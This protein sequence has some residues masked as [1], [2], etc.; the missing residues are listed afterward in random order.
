MKK[1]LYFLSLFLSI[2]IFFLSFYAIMSFEKFNID[3]DVNIIRFLSSDNM[4]GRLPG[5]YGNNL[6]AD[7][8]KN[9]FKAH[10]LKPYNNDY[11]ESFTIKTPVLNG[12]S[13]YLNI[14]DKNNLIIKSYKYG[15]DFKE[16]FLSLN[17]CWFSFSADDKISIKNNSLYILHNNLKY[18]LI[19]ADSLEMR[20][21]YIYDKSAPLSILITQD[22]YKDIIKS[23]SKNYIVE[24][25]IP[26]S[27]KDSSVCNVAGIIHG[28]NSSLPPLIITAHYDHVGYDYNG[29]I[30]HGALDN[31][32]GTAFMLSLCN[33]L[34]SMLPPERDIIFVAFNCEEY[35]FLGSKNFIDKNYSKIKDAKVLNFD[36]IG[37]SASSPLTIMTGSNND[38]PLYLSLKNTASRKNI[39]FSVVSEDMSDHYSFTNRNID[40]VT[41][42]D[43][44]SL[45]IH[46]ANDTYDKINKANIKRA[47]SLVYP[48][49]IKYAYGNHYPFFLYNKCTLFISLLLII[50]LFL[51]GTIEK[52][53]DNEI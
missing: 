23:L 43:F 24:G 8:I 38:S 41:I 2:F 40:A 31:A 49:I 32:S 30:Y 34:S 21:S 25:N 1:K 16:S 42:C 51:I 33:T 35:G 28:I 20:Y 36:M 50:F 37:G 15:T 45:R 19:C 12:S 47:Y 5:T 13:P 3:N 48:D 22:V 18:S 9:S 17:N 46:T 7:Y 39:N 11:Y 27:V 53:T 14:K 52:K 6:A 26:Y 29:K 4:Q 10:N 44:D